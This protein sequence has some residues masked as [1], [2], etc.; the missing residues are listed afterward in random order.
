MIADF[1][2]K[3]LIF[4]ILFSI[5]SQLTLLSGCTRHL[6]QSEIK[7]GPPLHPKPVDHIPD[8]QPKAEPLSRYGNPA[9]YEVFGKKYHVLTKDKAKHGH[10]QSGLASWY[11]AKFHGRRTSSG[12]PYDLYGMTAA[13]RHLPI[14]TYVKV[15]NLKNDKEIVVKINDRGPFVDNRIIDL[16]YAAA[17][18]LGIFEFGTA[19]VKITIIDPLHP[20]YIRKKG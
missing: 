6:I 16:S 15:K 13:H 18:K 19:P 3:K 9:V 8:A 2:N 1:S 10:S 17:K 7:D 14:P 4:F 20:D 5:G 12:E 11:G